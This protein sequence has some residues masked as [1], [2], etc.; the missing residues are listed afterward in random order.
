MPIRTLKARGLR[1]HTRPPLTK[2]A[3]SS[4]KI[5][6]RLTGLP[7]STKVRKAPPPRMPRR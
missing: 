5:G 2:S 3:G 7:K 1:F 6:G 4:A